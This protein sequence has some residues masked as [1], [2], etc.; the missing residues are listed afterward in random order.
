MFRSLT[1]D[2]LGARRA[3]LNEP[4]RTAAEALC[5]QGFAGFITGHTHHPELVPLGDGFYA[6]SGC[7]VMAVEPRDAWARM[8][9]VFGGVIR[10]S[11]IE[12]HA[13]R[14]VE[15]SLVVA[16][17]PVPGATRVERLVSRHRP[18]R[19]STPTT[20]TTLPGGSG[21]PIDHADF[22]AATR[23]RRSRRVAAVVVLVAALVGVLSSV[24]PPSRGRLRTLLGLVPVELPQVASA[25]LVFA[26][27][28]LLLIA[29][30]L[31]RGNRLAWLATLGLLVLSAVLH[32]VKG[33]D[34]EEA[35]F[36]A[37][38]AGWLL[39]RSSAF[40]IRPDSASVRRAMVV[41][42]VGIAS[43]L[44]ASEILVLGLGSHRPTNA[45]IGALVERL[46]G[47]S[48][49][50]LPGDTPFVTPA[51]AATGLGLAIAV[52]VIL[53]APRRPPKPSE[54]Q[55]LAD[56]ARAR[57]ILELHGGDT[58][59]Y[60]ALRDDKRWFFTGESMVAYGVRNGVCLVSPD[61]IGPSEDWADV[62][63]DFTAF[64]DQHGWTLAV[65]GAGPGW[66]PVYEAAGM[67]S[68]YMG[69]EAIV[70]CQAFT[71]D[72]GTMKGLR[73]SYN[74]VKKAGFT[75]IFLAPHEVPAALGLALREMMADTRQGETE[76]GFSM[77][78]SR[79]FDPDDRNLLLSVAL[80][81]T[82]RPLA[83]CQW[84]PAADIAGWS[85]DLTRRS[86]A[87][88]PNGVADFLIV[89]T[90]LHLKE[91]HQVGLGL[92]FAVMR[93][94]VA[95]EREGGFSNLER[96][97]LHKFSETMQ[98]ESLWRYNEKF[99]PVLATALCRPRCGGARRRP[100]DRHR[101]RRVDL[102]APRARALLRQG[103]TR[104]AVVVTGA[105]PRQQRGGSGS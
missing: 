45:T 91:T 89:E 46:A 68:I 76:R 101:R 27:I 93:E 62:W 40:R 9:P 69:D 83:F 8:P 33:G 82:G 103:R 75:S 49:I 50:P 65:L 21:W 80:D 54:R 87:E 66:L 57:S 23:T 53:L 32:L 24:T 90:I 71:L 98:I 96:R 86:K 37:G 39:A 56:R 11:W 35:L 100:D 22:A 25:T 2:G 30:G 16:E 7:G 102:R 70:D 10:R 5:A 99:R 17:T 6:N 60:F 34:V 55:H 28:S 42:S 12:V 85:L 104:A 51:L 88:Q 79:I 58:L 26:S 95:G 78:L 73:G 15:V 97:I 52:A 20:V 67:Q 31:R 29:R 63:S 4:A 43:A 105:E 36:T 77:T 84:V 92:N 41:S 18:S 44:A 13:K 3:H 64:A 1:T 61:P 94:I 14:E 59:A 38:T 81:P 48:T 19:P 72:G 47:N 74:R